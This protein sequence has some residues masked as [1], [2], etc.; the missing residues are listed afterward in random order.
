MKMLI[1]ESIF[2][3]MKVDNFDLILI[4][5]K[6]DGEEICSV[7]FEEEELMDKAL[8][9]LSEDLRLFPEKKQIVFRKNESFTALALRKIFYIDE[10]VFAK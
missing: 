7:F 4:G 1:V 3:K 5:A 10:I 6:I 2:S 9:A 8:D